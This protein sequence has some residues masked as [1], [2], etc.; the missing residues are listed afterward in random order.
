MKI[1]TLNLSKTYAG[2]EILKDI[3]LEIKEN[4][5]TVFIGHNGAGKTTLFKILSLLEKPT[6]GKIFFSK[7]EISAN[8]EKDSLN[9]RRKI[10]MVFQTPVLFKDS[11]FNNVGYGLKVRRE[12]KIEIK[13]KVEAALKQVQME[14][15]KNQ[16]ALT[17]SGGEIQRVVLAQRLVINPEV[18]FLDEPTTNIDLENTKIIEEIILNLKQNSKTIVLAT[19]NFSQAKKL[20]DEIIVINQGTIVAVGNSETILRES[21][22]FEI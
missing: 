11:V 7:T 17:L 22:K 8:S 3:N 16:N 5:I 6:L 12:N 20:A 18:I 19:H 9:L 14:K 2:K 10:S 4:K 1:K 13:K 21:I 15:L